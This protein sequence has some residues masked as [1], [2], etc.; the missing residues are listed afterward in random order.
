M[1]QEQIEEIIDKCTTMSEPEKEHL[2]SLPFVLDYMGKIG[3]EL[4]ASQDK[5]NN[6]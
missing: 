3:E 2:R 5:H 4:I 6:K 1:T